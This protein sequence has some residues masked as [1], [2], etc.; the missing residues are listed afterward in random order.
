MVDGMYRFVA[1]GESPSTATPPWND[2]MEG[3]TKAVREIV[4]AT[5]REILDRDDDLIMPEK[6]AFSGVSQLAVTA[7]AG[8][9]I[10]A[11]L[12]GLVPD[13][14]LNSGKRTAESSYM[15]LVD[16][17][18]LADH[19]TQE[20][21]IE[22]LLRLRPDVVL[23]V[24]GTDGGAAQSMRKQ[25]ETVAMACSLMENDQRPI[26]VYAGNRD[27]QGEAQA[28]LADDVG[29][30]FFSADNVRPTLESERLD[31]AQAKLASLY[32]R[33]K[34]RGGG[35]TDI[36]EWVKGGGIFP[37]AHGFSRAVHILGTIGEQNV[38]GID[39]GSASTT[40][41]ACLK[42]SQ[43]LNVHDGIGIGHSAKT[44]L[45][46]LK[47]ESLSRWLTFELRNPEDVSD[48]ICNKWL[49]PQTVPASNDSLEFEMALAR[50]MIRSA[51]LS[52]R[53]SWRGIQPRGPLPE[54]D[55]ILLAGSTLA[56]PASYG[57]SA[58][59]ALDGLLPLGITRLM[60]DPYGLA[61]A[62][63]AVAPLS[64]RAVVQ[65]L[66]TGAFVDLG[67]VI[68]LSGMARRG[69]VVLRG[70]LKPEG[71]S[72]ANPFEV[73]HGTIVAL[74]L[75]FG[76]QAEMTLQLS[77]VDIGGRHPGKLKI[78][79]GELGVVIDA[80]GRPWRFPRDAAQRREMNLEWQKSMTQEKQS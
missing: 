80:R 22:S 48:Y 75:P 42:G 28:T 27:L 10:R 51:I 52:S 55:T 14:S 34:L 1:R 39:L 43:Y 62:L 70:S 19:R 35:F 76:V 45:T 7:S 61:S 67:T 32:H 29:V 8:K 31:S 11:V 30:H 69:E 15:M 49:F 60:L 78:S 4:A 6:D 37:T 16:T 46:Q 74:P 59:V 63:G 53:L 2:V 77:H 17:F 64:Q 24:G 40:V 33:Q 21:Q 41:A 12:V 66:D 25:L 13:I 9:P 68:S 56:N 20:Q 73:Q 44:L 79:G 65:V 72:K 47:P 26:V 58:L 5:G 71:S 54:F 57:W 50:E 38:L 36:G 3:V 23:I 18:S